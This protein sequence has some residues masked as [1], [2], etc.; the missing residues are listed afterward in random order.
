MK[1]ISLLDPV[2]KEIY[3]GSKAYKYR[4]FRRHQIDFFLAMLEFNL[5]SSYRWN[6]QCLFTAD[7]GNQ[8]LCFDAKFTNIPIESRCTQL[9]DDEYWKQCALKSK[10]VQCHYSKDINS[11]EE[12]NDEGAAGIFSEDCL[13]S[14]DNTTEF[15]ST[16]LI[17]DCPR[18]KNDKH[19]FCYNEVALEWKLGLLS[20]SNHWQ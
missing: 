9:D 6:R 13:N 10:C 7:F 4:L 3:S 20:I 12:F 14:F 5:E 1:N 17:S 18:W 2:V 8:L 16:E 15:N 11:G 19:G